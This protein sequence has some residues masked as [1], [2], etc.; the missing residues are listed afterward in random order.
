MQENKI[1]DKQIT[2]VK[3][4]TKN[5]VMDIVAQIQNLFGFN[6]RSYENMIT[7]AKNQ[8]QTELKNN[9]ITMKWYRYEITQLTNGAIA[10]LFYG[11]KK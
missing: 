10:V 1:T 6:L 8:I 9:N 5:F 11:D 3:V 7:N 2:I 4:V